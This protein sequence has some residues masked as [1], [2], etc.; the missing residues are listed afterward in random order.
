LAH[1]ESRKVILAALAGN[2][3]IAVTKLIAA[4]YTGSGSMLSEAIHSAVDSGN[5]GLMLFGLKRSKRPADRAHPFGYGMELY[6]WAFVVALL[7]F[8]LGGG[9][10]IYEGIHK[11]T[12]PEPIESAWVAFAVL[13]A[14]ILF[15]GYSFS[16]AWREFRRGRGDHGT[17]R[18]IR[19]SKDPG[20]FAVLLEDAA[21]L[22]GLLFALAGV[23]L[24][25]LLDDPRFDAAGS[26]A[27]GLLLL[28]VAIFMANET[29]SLLVGE[30]AAPAVLDDI[31]KLITADPR[32]VAVG[33]LRSMHF[34]PQDILL[35]ATVD[36]RDTIPGGEVETAARELI[37]RVE[38]GGFGITR[39]YLRPMRLQQARVAGQ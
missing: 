9:V 3:A 39:A 35:A 14:A 26:I 38:T 19:Q 13:G 22:L 28:A 30:S 23:G 21:A 20:I 33:E 18:A 10:S 17:L 2:L 36:F 34:G 25:L 16:V 11:L 5:Q 32:V 1:G 7:I 29:R 8:A 12:A 37:E 4:L 27:I 6:F 15:E 31:R 24:T